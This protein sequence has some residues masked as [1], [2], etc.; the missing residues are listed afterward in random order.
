M[1]LCDRRRKCLTFV[2]GECNVATIQSSLNLLAIE[3]NTLFTSV[4]SYQEFKLQLL[5]SAKM[6][7]WA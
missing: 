4:C 7:N 6:F 1:G 3:M 5:L 2:S